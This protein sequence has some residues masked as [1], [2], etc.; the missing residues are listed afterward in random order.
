MKYP[1]I[2]FYRLEKFTNIDSFF[3]INNEKLNCSIFFTSNTAD[4]N[5]LFDFNYQILV[6]YGNDEI[7]YIPNVMSVITERMRDRWIHF[8][9]IP[10]ID[11]FNRAINYC[12]IHNCTYDREHVR[13]VFSVFTPTYNSYHKIERAYNSLKAQTLK[14]W[15]F[16]IIDDSPDDD[17]FNFLRKLMIND[18][19]V[20]LYRRG[21]NSGNIG[22]VKNEAV[23]LCR[24][25]YVLEFDHDDEILPFV[26]NDAAEHFD[27]NEDVG[28]IYMDCISLYENGSNHFYGDF[29]CKG[30]GS[31]Y[32]QKYGDKWVYVYNT[33]NIN[34]ITLSHLVCCPN[35]P[36]IWR[37]TALID[38]GSYCEFLPI[39]DDYEIILR[40]AV[41]TKMTKIHKFGY[42]QYMND[43]NNNFSLI[44]NGEINR[45]GPEFISPMFYEK[46]KIK[47]HMKTLD[48]YENEEYINNHSKIWKREDSYEHKYCNQVVNVDYD[49]QYCI[50]GLD[51]LTINIE[52]I[53]SLYENV[54]NDFFLIE[55]KCNIEQLHYILDRYGFS[56]FKC[57]TLIDETPETLIKYFMLKYKSCE[58]YEIINNYVYKMKYNTD[59]SQRHDVINY[60]SK[61]DNKYLEI[62]V[63]TGYTFN[64]VHF[65]NK[66]GV[67]PLPHFVSENLV[68][69]TSDDYFDNLDPNTNTKFDIVF[70]DGL[71]QC[72]QVVKDINNSIRFLNENGKI[73]LDDIIPLN[74]DEQL[75]IPVKHQYQNGVLK[76][77]IPW[78]GDVWKTMYHILSIYSQYIEFEYFYHSYYRGVAVL[79]IKEP[80]Q[81]SD[82]EI[83][84]INNY[85]Y[86][87]DFY[88][89][90][91]LIENFKERQ[92]EIKYTRIPITDISDTDSDDEKCK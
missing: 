10:G 91:D 78:T 50:V 80:F 18:S 32:C 85:N 62:G 53:T 70:I 17:H 79:Q 75:K 77:L 73:L 21:E 60:V 20:R 12:F 83:N 51:S 68:L 58:N 11:E 39:C 44:R 59:F 54:K 28:F 49:K 87:N 13:P 35:H 64:N 76:T 74:H 56:R 25:K 86:T 48:A 29:I 14:D 90:I 16:V 15:E 33:P 4:L 52:K 89:Y 92:N 71:H 82:S 55:N 57:Y 19:R 47:E 65:S 42:I 30:Y 31:Y 34:N 38:A 2:I 61:P 81:I 67:D 72:E 23:S 40:T 63:E 88:I 43:N 1:Y 27:K 84:V 3:I 24:G 45:I 26:L 6:T 5:K 7:E 66:I 69:K 8:K 36:R 22:N 41:N 46:F 9:E 37:K